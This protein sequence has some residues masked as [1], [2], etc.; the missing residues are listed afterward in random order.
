MVILKIVYGRSQN[1]LVAPTHFLIDMLMGMITNLFYH[2]FTYTKLEE[3]LLCPK[4]ILTQ[5]LLIDL[6][7]KD[8]LIDYVTISRDYRILLKL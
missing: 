3:R 7:D 1:E 4:I 2:G 5:I 6:P 8:L